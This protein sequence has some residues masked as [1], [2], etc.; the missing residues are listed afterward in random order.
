MSF[1]PSLA[2]GVAWYEKR[3]LHARDESWL[4]P[5]LVSGPTLEVGT[6]D[7]A[8]ARWLRER[9][10]TATYT[11]FEPSAKWAAVSHVPPVNPALPLPVPEA[12]QSN[13]LCLDLLE[14]LRMDQLYMVIAESRRVLSAGGRCFLRTLHPSPGLPARAWRQAYAWAPRWV[15]GRRPLDLHHY[16]SPEDWRVLHEQRDR[17]GWLNRQ[18]VVL[19]RL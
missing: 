8:R 19:E 17:D 5:F 10:P 14:Y 18:S 7:G 13:V 4:A 6:G 15:G 9:F 1:H 3:V 16:I 12:S 11:G 2:G